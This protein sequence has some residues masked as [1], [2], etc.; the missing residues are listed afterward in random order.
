MHHCLEVGKF[1][2][3]GLVVLAE[4]GKVGIATDDVVGTDGLGQR[5]EVEV[6]RVADGRGRGLGADDG[7]LA[8]GIDDGQQVVDVGLGDVLAILSR[9]ATSS[10]SS[11]RRAQT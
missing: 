9:V 5:E 10:T 1:H 7:E 2:D 11:M 4:V 8:E 6:L 3:S